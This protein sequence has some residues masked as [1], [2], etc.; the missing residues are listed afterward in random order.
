MD[1]TSIAKNFIY[2][3]NYL[4]DQ[5][6]LK[7][8]D[9]E[10]NCSSL[11]INDDAYIRYIVR[12]TILKY[13]K[14]MTENSNKNKK[15]QTEYDVFDSENI[16]KYKEEGKDKTALGLYE[17]SKDYVSIKSNVINLELKYSTIE[18]VLN[19]LNIF[20]TT[21]YLNYYLDLPNIKSLMINVLRNPQQNEDSRKLIEK[22]LEVNTK[23]NYSK[24]TNTGIFITFFRFLATN[25]GLSKNNIFLKKIPN[26]YK[27]LLLLCFV[28]LLIAPIIL[29]QKN[30]GCNYF[31]SF[32]EIKS[33]FLFLSSYGVSLLYLFVF[34]MVL[35]YVFVTIIYKKIVNY[36]HSIYDI[37]KIHNLINIKNFIVFLFSIGLYN[38]IDYFGFTMLTEILTGIQKSYFTSVT[39]NIGLMKK[40]LHK[41]VGYSFSNTIG[42][43][44]NPIR[45]S[46]ILL[47]IYL[48][49]V[50]WSSS[51]LKLFGLK[52]AL[53]GTTNQLIMLAI[54]YILFIYIITWFYLTFNSDKNAVY[55][56]IIGFLGLGTIYAGV[57]AI[58]AYTFLSNILNNCK[59]LNIDTRFK[60]LKKKEYD[61][62]KIFIDIFIKPLLP[63]FV[64][65]IA[66]YLFPKDTW[67]GIDKML[68]V[69]AVLMYIFFNKIFNPFLG[70][71]SIFFIGLIC[72]FKFGNV[73]S[74][75]R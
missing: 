29:W 28:I 57:S 14:L 33:L 61:F 63:L 66:L 51:M 15:I 34:V 59:S 3:T 54:F 71:V 75:F 2:Q 42:K 11:K 40:S 60:T 20:S 35:Y 7:N 73:I 70:S 38:I 52:S 45:F 21:R 19:M 50:N 43:T 55:K 13:F 74:L 18:K 47:C 37:T 26:A 23:Y 12:L 69:I 44:I 36:N 68:F 24:I 53:S 48:F 22:V 56:I 31:K 46:F 8:I 10:S 67:K 25:G 30:A 9:Y 72:V 64:I 62:S 39:K 41:F 17:I 65:L 49:S 4:D 5:S 27:T 58:Y 6:I 1:G 32:P 16:L